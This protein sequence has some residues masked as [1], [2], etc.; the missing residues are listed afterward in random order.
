MRSEFFVQ[1]TLDA[2]SPGQ[3]YISEKIIIEKFENTLFEK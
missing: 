3:G 1:I 2:H